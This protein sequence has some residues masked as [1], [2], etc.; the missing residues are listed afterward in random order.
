MSEMFEAASEIKEP[1][2]QLRDHAEHIA[3]IL[4][5]LLESQ[6][7]ASTRP[8]ADVGEDKVRTMIVS[9]LLTIERV[10]WDLYPDSCARAGVQRPMSGKP[11]RDAFE[12]AE[13]GRRIPDN[14]GK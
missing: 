2:A 9:R 8:A 13:E 1:L 5:R 3:G 7:N 6:S 10:L 12:G 4:E 11:V 14:G